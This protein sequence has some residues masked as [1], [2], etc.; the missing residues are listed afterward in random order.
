[1][2]SFKK[3][4][5]ETALSYRNL[6]TSTNNNKNDN[7]DKDK[8]KDLSMYRGCEYS[9][10]QRQKHKVISNRCVLYAQSQG[11]NAIEIASVYRKSNGWLT[12][13]AFVQGIHDCIDIYS[14]NSNN[15]MKCANNREPQMILPSIASMIPPP[16]FP[17]AIR[18]ALAL[19]KT[20]KRRTTPTTVTVDDQTRRVR[21]R[22]VC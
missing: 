20:G 2:I 17:F 5:R 18:S 11:M 22:Q 19:R 8:D 15:T 12:D 14:T 16:L 1:M 10:I 4:A 13:V 21:Q 6:L 7:D 9:S 3:D